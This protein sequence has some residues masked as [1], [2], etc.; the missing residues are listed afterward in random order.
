MAQASPPVQTQPAENPAEPEEPFDFGAPPESG[1]PTEY[2]DGAA[3]LGN[4]REAWSPAILS[5]PDLGAVFMA[6]ESGASHEDLEKLDLPDLDL[7]LDDLIAS[8]MLRKDGTRYRPAFPIVRDTGDI[9]LREA[10]RLASESIYLDLR[11]YF[12]KAQKAARK[13]KVLPWLYALIASEVF[14]SRTAEE[15]LVDAGALDARRMHDE[16]YFWIQIPRDDRLFSVDRYGSGSETLQYLWS[17]VTDMNPTLQDFSTR[18]L[19]LDGSLAHLPWTDPQ[20]E[21]AVRALGLLDAQKRVM[22]PALRK[23]SALLGI[24]RQASQLYVKRALAALRGGEL[25]AKLGI[26]RDE[27]FAIA[28]STLGA[29]SMERVKKDGWAE[30]PTLLI[31]SDAPPAGTLSTL[32]TT[33]EESFRPLDRAYYLYDRGDYEASVRQARDYLE[34]HPDDPEGFFRV[35]IAYM[36][37]RKYPEALAAFEKGISLPAGEGDVWKGWLYLRAGNTLDMLDRRDDALA[38]YHKALACADINGSRE[39]AK[40]W[41]EVV[42]RD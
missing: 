9:V 36:K 28:F 10:T 11:P 35:G 14:E 25:A 1:V 33:A 16:G 18:R 3:Y 17:P 13:E 27:T 15:M 32:V 22:I 34:T 5:D 7:A 31:D 37:L 20:T 6:A 26:P 8:R 30:Q 40:Q 42:Y 19:L 24:L 29:A 2:L 21:E 4:F 38:S 41:L 23:N 12:K 39:I